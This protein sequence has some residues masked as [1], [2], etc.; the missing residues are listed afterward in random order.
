MIISV[1]RTILLYIVIILAIRIMGK[2][3]IGELQTSE[4]VV[5]LLISDIAAIPMQNTE[6]SLL[7]G[8]VPILILIVCEIIISFLMLKRAGFRRIICGKPI[9]IIS[10]G[11]INQSEMHRL[12]MS[13]EDL[14]EE[15]RQQGIFNIED[16]GFAIVETNGK[17]SVL[18]KPEKDIPTAEEL[19]I[20]TKDKGLEV[21]VISDGEISK[22][23]LKICGLSR[24][25]LFDTLKKENTEL[26]DVF[27]MIANGQG[28]YKIIEKEHKI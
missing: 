17:L 1:I 23:S 5:T 11:K 13:T 18:K 28:E 10:D 21:V 8:I 27:L 4:L 26:N 9:V 14:S 16:V 12:R 6:Q 22:C 3:Q 24:D 15:L 2:R 7:S 25:W 19:G 20:K